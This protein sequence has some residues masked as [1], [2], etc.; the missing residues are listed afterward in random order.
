MRLSHFLIQ[1]SEF[2]MAKNVKNNSLDLI[3]DYVVN[4]VGYNRFVEFL[5]RNYINSKVEDVLLSSNYDDVFEDYFKKLSE[6]INQAYQ[7]EKE[8]EGIQENFNI[9]VFV[10]AN[11]SNELSLNKMEEVF[12]Q[13]NGI[14]VMQD[15]ILERATLRLVEKKAT[16]KKNALPSKVVG[17]P[18]KEL[19]L[20][21]NDIDYFLEKYCDQ[22]TENGLNINKYLVSQIVRS[23]TDESWFSSKQIFYK[24]QGLKPSMSELI[25]PE[26]TCDYI[27]QEKL[28]E[29]ATEQ[30]L[31]A[32]S[33]DS[34]M[35]DLSAELENK[36]IIFVQ[37]NYSAEA[38]LRGMN[39]RF[40]RDSTILNIQSSIASEVSEISK[41]KDVS[42]SFWLEQFTKI[43]DMKLLSQL[44]KNPSKQ[45]A[46]INDTLPDWQEGEEKNSFFKVDRTVVRNLLEAML[47][48][49]FDK[50]W[51]NFLDSE[52]LTYQESQVFLQPHVE[53]FCQIVPNQ[54]DVATDEFISTNKVN[55]LEGLEDKLKSYAKENY[56]EIFLQKQINFLFD[57]AG[58]REKILAGIKMDFDFATTNG[59]SNLR[60]NIS[61]LNALPIPKLIALTRY[62]SSE[63]L[64]EKYSLETN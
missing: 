45:E 33:F 23:L 53:T 11:Y 48:N 3:S 40:D 13:S 12:K 16:F 61:K 62:G 44:Y 64:I 28:V 56:T 32:Y 34:N 14:P 7:S 42:F 22:Q 49:S 18:L 39:D 25:V 55:S 51:D 59:D 24:D 9:K 37:R 58:T 10:N 30:F 54:V 29:E 20:S 19:A 41:Y 63:I 17:L 26:N 27:Q 43:T 21:I 15:N 5:N 52:G 31:K 57:E 38:I 60:L 8:A 46:Y 36:V 50:A 4:A 2:F 1:R 47:N 6:R 35:S